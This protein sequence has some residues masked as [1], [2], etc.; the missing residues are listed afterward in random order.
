M[1]QDIYDSQLDQ[2]QISLD[3]VRSLLQDSSQLATYDIQNLKAMYQKTKDKQV[4]ASLVVAYA[5]EFDFEQ[6]YEALRLL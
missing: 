2:A 1:L 3:T 5:H 4:L 6:A